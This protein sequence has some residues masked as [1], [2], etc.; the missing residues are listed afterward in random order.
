MW[1]KIGLLP[2]ITGGTRLLDWRATQ[3]LP[4]AQ[5]PAISKWCND[6]ASLYNPLLMDKHNVIM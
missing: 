6:T 1:H 2:S 4:S 3:A 5:S